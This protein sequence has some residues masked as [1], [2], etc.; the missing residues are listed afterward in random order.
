MLI[1]GGGFWNRGFDVGRLVLG[2]PLTVGRPPRLDGVVMTHPDLDHSRGLEYVLSCYD[3]GFFATNGQWPK[4]ED[5]AILTDIVAT[6]GLTLKT[7]AR[8]DR[9]DLGEGVALEV[10]WPG[11]KGGHMSSNDASLVLRLVHGSRPLA[12]LPADVELPAI[13]ALLADNATLGAEVLLLPHH[14]SRSSLSREL[15]ER[16]SPRLALASAGYLHPFGFPHQEVLQAL[17]EQGVPLY[18]TS[19]QGAVSV[20]WGLST[21][22]CEVASHRGGRLSN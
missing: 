8:G 12:L 3:V 16:V 14:G 18:R 1:D 5:G 13:Q 19:V 15:Y 2:A 7:L 17:K 21:G 9:L 20:S 10:L 6:R 22:E 11:K 4:G